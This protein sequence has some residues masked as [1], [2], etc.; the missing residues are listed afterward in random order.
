MNGDAR[1]AVKMAA[2]GAAPARDMKEPWVWSLQ[3]VP[4]ALGGRDHAHAARAQ[5]LFTA[6]AA[7]IEDPS[8]CEAEAAFQSF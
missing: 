5:A 8:T 1:T 6:L 3:G 7:R 2:E 4:E